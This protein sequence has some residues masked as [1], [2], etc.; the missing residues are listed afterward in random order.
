MNKTQNQINEMRAVLKRAFG[1]GILL[2][3]GLIVGSDGDTNQYLERSPDYLSDLSYFAITFLGIVCPYPETPLYRALASENRLLPGT[4]RRDY[5]CYTVCHGPSKLTPE[6][7]VDHYRNLCRFVGS[8]SS[9]AR[10]YRAELFA[11]AA[12]R[13]KSVIFLSGPEI[14]SA[15]NPLRNEARRYIAGLDPIEA[16]DREKM[17]ELSLTPQ[18]FS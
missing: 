7:V 1:S 15:R 16:W 18:R 12:P 3:S 2:A 9:V 6:E 14:P 8:Y 5:D 13:Y 11:S 4:T 10:H 17:T